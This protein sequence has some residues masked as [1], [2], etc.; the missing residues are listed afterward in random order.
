[1]VYIRF[2]KPPRSG[3]SGIYRR[4]RKVGSEEGLSVY[5]AIYRSDGWHV[6]LPTPL[7]EY[8]IGTLNSLYDIV[9]SRK[10]K[11]FLISG[12]EI[13]KGSD[14]EPL[15]TDFEILDDITNKIVV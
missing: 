15:I 5:D 10:R 11:V 3:R 6:V 13:G 12:V 2:G 4:G 7:N 8:A 9:K 14:G 1:M